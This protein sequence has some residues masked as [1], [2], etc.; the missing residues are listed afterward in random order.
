M[1]GFDVLH[2]LSSHADPYQ[3]LVSLRAGRSD[4]APRGTMFVILPGDGAIIRQVSDADNS[5]AV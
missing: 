5:R 2:T 4:A 1:L 3:F